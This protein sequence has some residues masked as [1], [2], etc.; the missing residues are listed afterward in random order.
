MEIRFFAGKGSPMAREEVENPMVN[1]AG[2]P[3]EKAGE[4]L[5]PRCGTQWLADG[6][7]GFWEGSLWVPA[8][9]TFSGRYCLD[10][11]AR[12]AGTRELLLGWFDQEGE[13]GDLLRFLLGD[14]PLNARPLG[15]QAR[16]LLGLMRRHEPELFAQLLEEYAQSPLG[17]RRTSWLAYLWGTC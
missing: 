6:D 5:C 12:E 4:I 17:R 14:P 7:G 8:P 1:G 10:C 16:L 3:G 9:L 11:A 13:E 2:F 15:E